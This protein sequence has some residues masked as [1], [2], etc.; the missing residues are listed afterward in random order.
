MAKAGDYVTIKLEE[1]ELEEWCRRRNAATEAIAL[2]F[3]G[4]TLGKDGSKV[5]ITKVS[6]LEPVEHVAT[7]DAAG[8]DVNLVVGVDIECFLEK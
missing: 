4:R 6:E 7:L 8:V 5:D 1:Q 2:D 3:I